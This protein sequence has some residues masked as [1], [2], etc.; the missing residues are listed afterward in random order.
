MQKSHGNDYQLEI[1]DNGV[2]SFRHQQTGEILHGSVGPEKEAEQLYIQASGLV[3]WPHSVATVFDIGMGCGA[4]LLALLDF[5]SSDSPCN[6]LDIFSFDLEK[7]GLKAALEAQAHF[8]SVRRHCNFLARACQENHFTWT[9]SNGKS[10][11]WTFVEGDFLQT[12]LAPK[13]ANPELKADFI[14]YDFF[15]PA[16][17]PW[18]WTHDLF[19]KLFQ[20]AVP[21]TRLVTYSSA[22][23]VK[24]ALAAAGWY[25]G[26][27]IPSGKKAHSI[28]AAGSLARLEN[29]LNSSFLGPF[30]RSH[31]PFCEAE[32]ESSK[33]AIREQ[34]AE[35]PQ[36]KSNH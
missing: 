12:I 7:N 28:L 3:H 13:I 24:A 35:H 27:T 4:Q 19:S 10:L 6:Q 26:T 5:L 29:P 25:V 33:R 18:L 36:F 16:S 30:E 9:M 20:Y 23:C 22:T 14:F 11:R 8:A 2:V 21:Q 1:L 31:K 17:H 15:S 32:S 34:L